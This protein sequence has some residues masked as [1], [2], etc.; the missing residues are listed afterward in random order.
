MKDQLETDNSGVT[1]TAPLLILQFPFDVSSVQ[2]DHR[3][4]LVD[5]AANTWPDIKDRSL[6]VVGFTDDTGPQRYNDLLALR[7]ADSVAKALRELGIDKVKTT[8]KGKCCYLSGNETPQGRAN[9]RR[10]E[11]RHFFDHENTRSRSNEH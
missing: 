6:M 11:I 7:R 3:H 4:V 2:A 9:N 1:S 5:F 8:A 10:V